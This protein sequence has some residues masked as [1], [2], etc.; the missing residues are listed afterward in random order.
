[1]KKTTILAISILVIAMATRVA[2]AGERED[3]IYNSIMKESFIPEKSKFAEELGRLGTADAMSKLLMLLRD[4]SSWNRAAAVRGLFALPDAGAGPELFKRMLSDHMINDDIAAGFRSRISAYYEFLTVKYRETSV[5]KDRERI[6]EI[7]SSSK[8][9]RGETFL[10]GIIEDTLSGD[11]EYAFKNLTVHYPSGNY[12]Y[13][14]NFRDNPVFRAHALTFIVERGKQEDLPIFRDILEKHDGV[15]YRLIA[16]QAVNKWG[17]EALRHRVFMDSLRE[18]DENLV[19]GGMYV[20]TGVRSDAVRTGLCRIVKNGAFQMTR[21]AAALRLKEYASTDIIPALVMILRE[22]YTQRERGG[23][24]I[25]ATIITFGIASVFDD[26]SQKRQ[27]TSF[28]NSKLEIAGHL[29]TITGTDNGVSHGRWYE[30]AILNGYSIMGDNI[31]R[32]L[33]SGYRPVR[34]KAVDHAIRLLGYSSGREFFSR[35]GNFTNDTELSLALARM[36]IAKGFLK[37]EE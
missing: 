34:Q 16:Y 21:M 28:D 2:M 5:R 3:R 27:K 1:M 23:P 25:F 32:H 18:S 4:Q 15:K 20:F 12:Q 6:I 24:D 31:I 35:N 36:L 29:K 13:I 33:F 7:I 30:W 17:D 10:K 26:I 14:K 11:R 37:D 8:A 19:Q 9:P 22:N